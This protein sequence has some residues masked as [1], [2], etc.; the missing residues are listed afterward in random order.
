MS[1]ELIFKLVVSESG[2]ESYSTNLSYEEVS[3][4]LKT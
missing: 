4:L 1:K 2:K 3:S